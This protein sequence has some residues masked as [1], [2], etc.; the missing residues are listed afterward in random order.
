[1]PDPSVNIETKDPKLFDLTSLLGSIATQFSPMFNPKVKQENQSHQDTAAKKLIALAGEKAKRETDAVMALRRK[2]GAI[3]KAK[4]DALGLNNL[5]GTSTNLGG[6]I[7]GAA[8]VGAVLNKA[9]MAKAQLGAQ[10]SGQEVGAEDAYLQDM[11]SVFNSTAQATQASGIEKKYNMMAPELSLGKAAGDANLLYEGLTRKD[12]GKDKGLPPDY[13]AQPLSE[14]PDY[15]KRNQPVPEVPLGPGMTQSPGYTE[16]MKFLP[17]PVNPTV[18]YNNRAQ[19]QNNPVTEESKLTKTE[20][21]GY[22]QNF[23]QMYPGLNKE[24]FDENSQY[25]TTDVNVAYQQYQKLKSSGV[26]DD[27][28]PP[29]MLELL[30]NNGIKLW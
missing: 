26:T 2:K 19:V 13:S 27:K 3:E 6:N 8:N 7:G 4:A 20:T 24:I 18:P 21:P 29:G 17:E 1:M 22:L 5:I 12:D 30:K 15:L 9:T 16:P 10:L 28:M 25:G 14:I 11:S 23:D